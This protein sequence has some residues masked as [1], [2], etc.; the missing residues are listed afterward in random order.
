MRRNSSDGGAKVY[1]ACSVAG[2]WR[3]RWRWGWGRVVEGGGSGGGG[4]GGG[5]EVKW[6][7]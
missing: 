3:W 4:G 2:V 6:S 5:G 7:K 1:V